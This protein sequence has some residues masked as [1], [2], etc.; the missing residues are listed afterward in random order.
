MHT[1]VHLYSVSVEQV[2]LLGSLDDLK[3]EVEWLKS[4]L[5]APGHISSDGQSS[6]CNGL[7]HFIIHVN[8]S[9][10]YTLLS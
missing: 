1:N 3:G 2:L 5:G 7:H 10:L 6:S 8:N 9:I 4:E